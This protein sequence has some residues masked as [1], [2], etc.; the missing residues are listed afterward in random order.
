VILVDS[1]AVDSDAT[2]SLA[3]SVSDVTASSA[4][5]AGEETANY[6]SGARDLTV[7]FALIARNAT[8][9]FV[10]GVQDVVSGFGASLATVARASV[11]GRDCR[12]TRTWESV[13]T[14]QL[15]CRRTDPAAGTFA[16]QCAAAQVV[17]QVIPASVAKAHRC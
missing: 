8:A 7:N 2:P 14:S 12:R 3:V 17:E 13:I 4:S 16:V 1:V 6:V 10:S 15:H 5:G 11:T 9:N